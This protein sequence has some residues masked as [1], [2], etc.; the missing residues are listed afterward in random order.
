MSKSKH[1][2]QATAPLTLIT[3]ASSGIG[4]AFA[5]LLAAEGHPLILVAR[6]KERL[7]KLKKELERAH[8]VEIAVIQLDLAAHSAAARLARKLEDRPVRWL[9]NN[10]GVGYDAEF[11]D[12]DI[13]RQTQLVQLNIVALMKLTHQFGHAFTERGGGAILNVAS[14]ASFA[15]G[16]RQPVYF[17]SKAFVRSFSHGIRPV[18]ARKNVAVTVLHPGV[19][20]TEFFDVAQADSIVAGATPELVARVGYSALKQGSAEVIVGW[21]N[22]AF[23]RLLAPFLPFP[24]MAWLMTVATRRGQ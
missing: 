23:A 20:R 24:V 1:S 17:A 22:K 8:G 10:A 2:A 15:P 6:R 14:I 4:A 7:E 21:E 16:P 13:E 18:L 11:L 12:S 19:T 5:R 9:I 3:G